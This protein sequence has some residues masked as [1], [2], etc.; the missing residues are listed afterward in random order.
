MPGDILEDRKVWDDTGL[1]KI[2]VS[3][4]C[5]FNTKNPIKDIKVWYAAT[6]F[7]HGHVSKVPNPG[8]LFGGTGV[9]MSGL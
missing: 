6:A 1:S 7:T 9:A 3:C 4:I 8:K 2:K 5:L